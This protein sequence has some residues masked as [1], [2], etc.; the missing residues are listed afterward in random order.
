MRRA[1][2]RETVSVAA[3]QLT[4]FTRYLMMVEG[5]DR[6]MAEACRCDSR[7]CAWLLSGFGVYHL[8]PIWR[9]SLE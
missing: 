5:R 9:S 8:A 6:G 1:M 3:T 7:V 4:G 2:P